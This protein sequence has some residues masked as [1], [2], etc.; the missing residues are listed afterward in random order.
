MNRLLRIRRLREYVDHTETRS[1]FPN[2]FRVFCVTCYI[3]IIIH[4][5]ACAYYSLSHWIGL[6]TDTWVPR[7]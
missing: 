3:I 6:D 1:S 2:A 5:N 4:W 7:I